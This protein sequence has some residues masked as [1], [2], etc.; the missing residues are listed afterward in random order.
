MSSLSLDRT[1]ICAALRLSS[2]LS[3]NEDNF[4]LD[5]Q[6][7]MGWHCGTYDHVA[8]TTKWHFLDGQEIMEASH[9]AILEASHEAIRT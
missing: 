3:D 5:G 9:E 7:I 4:F 2:Q 6:E 1:C 8:D